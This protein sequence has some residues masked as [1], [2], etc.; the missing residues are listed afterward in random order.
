[1]M[2]AC[3]FDKPAFLKHFTVL[4][5]FSFASILSAPSESFEWHVYKDL[6]ITA[7]FESASTKKYIFFTYPMW[8]EIRPENP[9]PLL[10]LSGVARHYIESKEL[11]PSLSF[12]FLKLRKKGTHDRNKI[13]LSRRAEIILANLARVYVDGPDRTLARYFQSDNG[14]YGARNLARF[15]VNQLFH[16][17]FYLEGSTKID[18]FVT[19]ESFSFVEG[20]IIITGEMIS[21]VEEQG[22]LQVISLFAFIALDRDLYL[23]LLPGTDTLL[24]PSTFGFIGGQ[25]LRRVITK[26][27]REEGLFWGVE[28]PELSQADELFAVNLLEKEPAMF[29]SAQCGA[30]V[31]NE[32]ETV[33]MEKEAAARKKKAEK[34][35][36][37]KKRK[38]EREKSR[39]ETEK[40]EGQQ[41]YFYQRMVSWIHPLYW[42]RLFHSVSGKIGS[43]PVDPRWH[44]P[45]DSEPISRDASYLN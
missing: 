13:K 21:Q 15:L 4:V 23:M 39:R 16:V 40:P 5:I 31:L 35:K 20:S 45:G 29:C 8:A 26:T 27:R 19:D 2:W 38:K 14:Q 37:Y 28:E 25:E 33:T 36:Q 32:P 42:L 10:P 43:M 9:L 17:K 7:T 44:T 22:P 41:L 1:M 6:L 12:V 3:F 24:F 18:A 11:S 34:K 30:T